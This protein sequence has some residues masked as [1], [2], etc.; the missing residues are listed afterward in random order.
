M[1]YLETFSNEKPNIG[2]DIVRSRFKRAKSMNEEWADLIKERVLI[3]EQYAKQLLKLSKKTFVTDRQAIGT[4]QI[5]CERLQHEMSELSKH[6]S[7]LATELASQVEKPLRTSADLSLE[8]AEF[9]VIESNALKVSREYNENSTKMQ[10]KTKSTDKA[11][12]WKTN[13]SK[14]KKDMNKSVE[15][16]SVAFEN[17][18]KKFYE[19]AEQVDMI[20]IE[21]LKQIL[22]QY[23]DLQSQ[24]YC[25]T[26][27]TVEDSKM[28]YDINVDECLREFC[29]NYTALNVSTSSLGQ[30]VSKQ[31]SK[32]NG[33]GSWIMKNRKNSN[34]TIGSNISRGENTSSSSLPRESTHASLEIPQAISEIPVDEEGYSIPP[35]HSSNSVNNEANENGVH[36]NEDNDGS[37]TS[38]IEIQQPKVQ[39]QIQEKAITE[40]PEDVA[41]AF[42]KVTSTLK[43]QHGPGY[44]STRARR[45]RTRDS[46]IPAFTNGTRPHSTFSE[47]SEGNNGFSPITGPASLRPISAYTLRT[48]PTSP[49]VRGT[50]NEDPLLSTRTE[51]TVNALIENSQLKKL[52]ISGKVYLKV[53]QNLTQEQLSELSINFSDNSYQ[54]KLYNSKF[55]QQSTENTSQYAFN[56]ELSQKLIGKDTCILQYNIVKEDNFEKILPMEIYSVFNNISDQNTTQFSISINFDSNQQ[57]KS[58]TLWDRFV[59]TASLPELNNPSERPS[60]YTVPMAMW[61]PTEQTARWSVNTT[62]PSFTILGQAPM[63]SPFPLSLDFSIRSE[64]SLIGL[65]INIV[66][67]QNQA[68]SPELFLRGPIQISSGVFLSLPEGYDLSEIPSSKQA[69]LPKLEPIQV[70][71]NELSPISLSP[72]QPTSSNTFETASSNTSEIQETEPTLENGEVETAEQPSESNDNTALSPPAEVKEADQQ[73]ATN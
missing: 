69:T 49:E 59:I 60:I 41:L 37:D 13:S 33:F 45:D 3:E 15:E 30:N 7:N 20:R 65:D 62:H 71:I 64:K 42:S 72:T 4:I 29:S 51:E 34:S 18:M 17:E 40:N 56:S 55:I 23:A 22:F 14:K 70:T 38:S 68:L 12:F 8:P 32:D 35:P 11:M 24:L 58:Q 54:P 10:K 44:R 2:L 66:D 36:L 16:L 52:V 25:S 26:L 50:T 53:N 46:S 73:P 48:F 43:L 57:S 28:N 63:T 1:G 47:P 6:H 9:K 61:N 21:G 39:F 67:K 27:Q 5:Q 31:S 19:A